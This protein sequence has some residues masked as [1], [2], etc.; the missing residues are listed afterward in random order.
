[1]AYLILKF[2]H[3]L[4][5][6]ILFGTGLGTAFFM[7]TA[8][9]THNVQTLKNTTRHVV[10]ADWIFTSPAVVVQFVTGLALMKILHY[11]FNSI[12][13]YSVIGL[14]IFIGCCWLP[15]V[16]IQ[17]KLR[18]IV[19]AL[20]ANDQ[21]PSEFGKLMRWWCMLGCCAFSAIIVIFWLMVSKAG[22]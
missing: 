17:Y 2:I 16:A 4:S 14:Y 8:Y 20:A 7:F 3:I 18:N 22:L 1:M 6:T 10:W 19:L 11:P 21:L 5:A 12:W 9:C 15:V 13:F